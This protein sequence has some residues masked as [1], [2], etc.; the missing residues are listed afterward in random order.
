MLHSLLARRGKIY[1]VP[2]QSANNVISSFAGKMK[3]VARDCCG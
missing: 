2:D 1:P 3:E